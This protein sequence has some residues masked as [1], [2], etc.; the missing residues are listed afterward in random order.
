MKQLE[1]AVEIAKNAGAFVKGMKGHVRVSDK[2]INDLVTEADTKAQRMIEDALIEQFP[3]SRF[4]GEEDEKRDALDSESL[5][6]IDPLDGT[7][8]FTHTIPVYCVSIAYAS[9]G[10]V[11]CG[12]VYDPER[13]ELF[14]A[15]RGGGAYLNG[16]KI[17]VTNSASLQQAMVSVGFYYDRGELMEKTLCS[18]Q[19]LFKK[20]IR[21]IRRMGSAAIDLSWVACGRFDAYFEY[22]LSP[23]DYA[24][25]MLLVQE[26]GGRISDRDGNPFVLGSTGAV[27]SNGRFHEEFVSMVKYSSVRNRFIE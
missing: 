8:N 14:S 3:D 21:G 10:T 16:K 9:K 11:L 26:A 27:A 2:G 1:A 19:A 17:S 5:W 24:A 4:F 25:G 6:I 15:Q 12:C 20:N 13:D 22:F 18:V 23:W 7:N